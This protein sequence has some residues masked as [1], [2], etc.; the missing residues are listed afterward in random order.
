MDGLVERFNWT[1]AG[2]LAKK[3]NKTGKTG[4]NVYHMSYL[5]TRQMY[6]TASVY[7]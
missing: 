2:M 1:L 5:H 7:A 4:M 6:Y 3:V